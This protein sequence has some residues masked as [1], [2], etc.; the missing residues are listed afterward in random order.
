MSDR[1]SVAR[2]EMIRRANRKYY[3]S[4]SEPQQRPVAI[5][6]AGQPGA[7]KGR[8]ASKAEA[9]LAGK[10][11]SI[12]IDPDRL[13]E[14]HPNY[15]DYERQND[16]SAAGRVHPDASQWAKELRQD[17]IG[18]RRN[19][20]I[21]GTL[22]DKDKARELLG[23]LRAAGYETEIRA[24]AVNERE[25]RQ[26]VHA[27]YESAKEDGRTA[28]WV[29]EEIQEEAYKGMPV[30][31]GH[32]ER[33]GWADKV[34]VMRR[35][36]TVVYRNDRASTATSGLSQVAVMAER[37]R[38]PTRE[39]TIRQARAWDRIHGQMQARGAD[40]G[41]MAQIAGYRRDAVGQVAAGPPPVRAEPIP[42]P[43]AESIRAFSAAQ[44]ARAVQGR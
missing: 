11:G 38:D 22:N 26:G 10:G 17:A 15:R 35:D 43:G 44:K 36:G 6:I 16:R 39:E 41:D 12:L 20:I 32:I 3:L 23:Q 24:L 33:N 2:H 18:G 28:R 42:R 19:I 34:S 7:G 4:R 31:L 40:S 25:S 29:P 8:L 30:A 21:D 37:A 9:E 14:Q 5:I 1:L 27:R 13:R